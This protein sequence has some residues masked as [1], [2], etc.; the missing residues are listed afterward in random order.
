M[1]S[2][3]RPMCPIKFIKQQHKDSLNSKP[4]VARTSSLMFACFD[5]CLI[6][7]TEA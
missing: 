2:D 4:S 3:E 5:V 7:P 6:E 1:E